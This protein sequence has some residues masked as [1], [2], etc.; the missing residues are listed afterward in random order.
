MSALAGFAVGVGAVLVVS[1]VTAAF[2][3][4]NAF[5]AV[6]GWFLAVLAMPALAL[7]W[8]LLKTEVGSIPLDARSLEG[9]ARQK[10]KGG[11]KAW[12]FFYNRRG[13]VFVQ[14]MKDN[15]PVPPISVRPVEDW[16]VT[17]HG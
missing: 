2:V 4:R 13:V 17:D 8:L 10:R 5:Q 1:T 16:R 9:F 7:G 14:G 6:V 11:G 12:A 15:E 3:E